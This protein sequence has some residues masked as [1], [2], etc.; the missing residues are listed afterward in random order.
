MSGNCQINSLERAKNLYLH[1]V[2]SRTLMHVVVT[3]ALSAIALISYAYVKGGLK[4]WPFLG[5]NLVVA[6]LVQVFRY[7]H[8]CA[9]EKVSAEDTNLDARDDSGWDKP[10]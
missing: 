7:A 3:V 8:N 5:A 1:T 4:R 10:K 2:A 6:G 9:K